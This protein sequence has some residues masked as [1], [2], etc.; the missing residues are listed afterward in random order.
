MSVTSGIGCFRG[1]AGDKQGKIL[2]KNATERARQVQYPA[3]LCAWRFEQ[4]RIGGF[5]SRHKATAR[6]TKAISLK[7]LAGEAAARGRSP[8][9]MAQ[10]NDGGAVL[11]QRLSHS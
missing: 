2:G 3:W 7:S 10:R 8:M 9:G 11:W 6:T 4:L 5:P 1:A